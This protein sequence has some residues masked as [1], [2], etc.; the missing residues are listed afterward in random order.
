[1]SFLAKQL[2]RPK[3]VR[4]KSGGRYLGDAG[5]RT[6]ADND[7]AKR[8]GGW[9]L[10]RDGTDRRGET[11]SAGTRPSGSLDR[12]SSYREREISIARYAAEGFRD[13]AHHYGE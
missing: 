7:R 11:A 6:I 10:H 8:E 5:A 2:P 12:R 13:K 9:I 3:P 1:M 4:A